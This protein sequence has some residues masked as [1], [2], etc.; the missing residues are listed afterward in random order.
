M[1]L[2]I[3]IKKLKVRANDHSPVQKSFILSCK[4]EFYSFK[5]AK[6]MNPIISV[7]IP[8]HKRSQL[9]LR[10]VISALAQTL[11]EIEVIVVI[12]GFDDGTQTELSK[13]ADSRLR[14]VQLPTS[15]GGSG[16]RNA[17]VAEAKGEWI[18]FLDDDDEWL[19]QKLERQLELAKRSQFKLPIISCLLTAHTPKGEFIY[20]RRFP[21]PD[22]PLSEYLLTRNSFS[23]GEGLIQTSTIFTNRKLLERF[24][25]QEGLVKHQD[26][27]WLLKVN[28]LADVGIEF[29][30]E[31]LVIWYCWQERQ[32]TSSTSNWQQS[33]AWLRENQNLVTP[34]AYSGFIMTQVS[35][36]AAREGQWQVFWSLLQEAFNYGQPQ[37]IDLI[38]YCLMWFIPRNTRRSLRALFKIK[39]QQV[40]GV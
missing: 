28:T 21:K 13:I 27:D 4:R 25:F 9:V 8:T 5:K 29:V 38:L 22:E 33:L 36:Q 20:P 12:D 32:S 3:I 26:W 18:A 34:R 14:I 23:F 17:G 19:P 30:N 40:S 10:S 2:L 16:A 35:P 6:I 1:E 7:I 31:T 37:A 15:K 39:T 24:P 11:P